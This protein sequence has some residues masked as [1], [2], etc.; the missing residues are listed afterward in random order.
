MSE[1][2]AQMDANERVITAYSKKKASRLESKVYRTSPAA[3]YGSECWLLKEKDKRRVSL[4]GFSG[5]KMVSGYISSDFD[6]RRSC[7]YYLPMH[8]A[9]S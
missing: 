8:E 4:M 9:E 1:E 6:R 2:V 3:I 5:V 7:C